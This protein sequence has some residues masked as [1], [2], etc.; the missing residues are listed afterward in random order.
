MWEAS[1]KTVPRRKVETFLEGEDAHTLHRTRRIHF[2]RN[3]VYADTIDAVWQ[4]DLTDV[5]DLENENPGCRFLLCIV[6]VFSKFGWIEPI[7]SKSARDVLKGFE[8]V[9]A[10]TERRP[11]CLITDKG[12]EFQNQL[13]R[14]YLKDMD[15]DL[16][17]TE[18]PDTKASVCERWQRTIKQKLWKIFTQREKYVFTDGTLQ[19]VVDAYNHTYHRSIK[20]RPIDV[21]Q[22][23][24]LEVYNN[25]YHNAEFWRGDKSHTIKVGDYVR[26]SREKGRYEKGYHWNW[27][28]EIYRVI[29][30]IRH[31][32]AVYELEDLDGDMLK[33]RFYKEELQK[34]KKP[35]KFKIAYI[36]DTKGK[37]ARRQ[38]LVHWRGY[39]VKSRSWIPAPA[40]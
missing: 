8:A 30:I 27:S 5:Q 35:D 37:G 9:F 22:D 14:K 18:N 36:V 21:T 13:V 28:E 12:R 32:V 19:D 39:P 10:R 33:G 11:S 16:Y 17:N 24:V 1:G 40:K 25:L 7:A 29:K 31:P 4:A 20:M 2:K 34:V 23:R 26:I 38:Q 3:Q 15:V 6:D